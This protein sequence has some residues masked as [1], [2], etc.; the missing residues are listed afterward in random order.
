MPTQQNKKKV[1]VQ[2]KLMNREMRSLFV[3]I[4]LVILWPCT[5]GT[6]SYTN[7]TSQEGLFFTYYNFVNTTAGHQIFMILVETPASW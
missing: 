2:K 7:Y 5:F 3:A 6:A 4:F 1:I